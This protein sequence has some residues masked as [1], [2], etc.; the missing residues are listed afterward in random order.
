MLK[1]KIIDLHAEVLNAAYRL[2]NREMR[3]GKRDAKN[4]IE[5]IV[6]TYVTEH[7]DE[8]RKAKR[9]KK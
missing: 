4:F 1:R 5:D 3:R 2:A 9:K 7:D 8:L 6:T